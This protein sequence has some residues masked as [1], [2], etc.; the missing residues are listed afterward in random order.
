MK[1]EFYEAL[2]ER[3]SYYAISKTSP[4]SDETIQDVV[5]KAL[6]LAP[7]A[8]NSQ[9]ARAVV[10]F[11]EQHDKAWEITRESLRKIVPADQFAPT[12]EKIDSFKN[13]YGTVL[14]FE[15]QSIVEGLQAQFALYKDNFPVWAQQAAGMA[16]LVV[17]TGLRSE[18]LGASLQHYN[19]LIEAE[20]KASFDLPDS[21]KLLAQMPFGTP[22]A[23]PG[24]KEY[25]PIEERVRVFK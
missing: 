11:G 20:I 12:N 5:E 10:L 13:G 21:W 23:E 1:K 9:S 22:V 2:G 7:S 24:P 19:E 16:Q 3:R 6:K 17:W 14:F 8:F 25:A 15:E 18:G 4:V